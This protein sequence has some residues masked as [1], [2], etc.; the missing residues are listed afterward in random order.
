MT[1]KQI[2][3]RLPW[4][5]IIC[6]IF[7]YGFM[8]YQVNRSSFV[9]LSYAQLLCIMTAYST[10]FLAVRWFMV[11]RD[12]YFNPISHVLRY[13]LYL[14]LLYYLV[15]VL[16]LFLLPRHWTHVIYKAHLDISLWQV[17]LSLAV[18][19]FRYSVYACLI[20]LFESRMSA[21][22]WLGK[23]LLL[24]KKLQIRNKRYR[25]EASDVQ[26]RALIREEVGH[27]LRNL[28]QQVYAWNSFVSNHARQHV[29]HLLHY[30]LHGL[31]EEQT[32]FV[33]LRIEVDAAEHLNL[34]Y[35]EKRV[36]IRLPDNL[37][38][39]LVPRFML[40]S[41]IQNCQKHA[42]H[43]GAA[44]MEVQ[45]QRYGM[46]IQVSNSV[47]V[48]GN[49]DIDIAGTGMQRMCKIVH[50]YYAE[51]AEIVAHAV[52]D[53]YLLSIRIDYRKQI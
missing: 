52:E 38:G 2:V 45:L 8:L 27:L 5:F 23:R 9:H 33:A 44:A 19:F 46:H 3:Y 50:H 29:D 39:H 37:E 34:I 11:D 20:V 42:L 1:E 48:C 53:R 49:W 51:A 28:L 10:V 40:V 31:S 30:I 4:Y 14:Y 17:A 47:E 21:C 24:L 18:F 35:P 25:S 16:L 12:G 13:I 7:L 6:I 36:D 32:Q 43:D 41:L 26:V 22:I 15:V